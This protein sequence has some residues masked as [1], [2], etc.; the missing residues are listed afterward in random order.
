MRQN[1]QLDASRIVKNNITTYSSILEEFEEVEMFR[2]GRDHG[3]REFCVGQGT[4]GR[5]PARFSF[6]QSIYKG[7]S[8]NPFLFLTVAI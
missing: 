6:S 8:D 7:I 4:G 3:G 2:P 5:S 1:R